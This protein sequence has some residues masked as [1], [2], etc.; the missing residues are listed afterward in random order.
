MVHVVNAAAAVSGAVTDICQP[1]VLA[2]GAFRG[3][4]VRLTQSVTTVLERHKDPQVVS[5]LLCEATVAATALAGGLKYEGV[6]TLQAQAKGPVHTLIADITSTGD[7]RGC[8]KFDAGKLNAVLARQPTENLAAHL[9]GDGHLAFTVDQGVDTERYQGI[10][11][12]SGGSIADSVHRYF[13]Q[14]EQLPS[15]LMI[16]V[17]PPDPLAPQRLWRAAALVIQRMPEVGGNVILAGDEAEDAWRTAVILMGTAT[18]HE[19]L[20]PALTPLVLLH[21]LFG[22]IGV[23]ATRSKPIAFGCR[24]SRER[25]GRILASFPVEEVKSFADAGLVRM[26]CEFC[27]AEY[28]FTDAEIDMLA[29]N[30]DN[31]RAAE[32]AEG[33]QP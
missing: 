21:R 6:F 3:R 12:L 19:L 32:R 4:L 15:V 25:S 14:S 24:C 23:S 26:T 10:V 28:V 17:A 2:G 18:R 11:E 30:F 33:N 9:L 20:D 16:A 22:T 31:L 8:A 7:L 1:F 29:I 5:Q 13:H 27:C